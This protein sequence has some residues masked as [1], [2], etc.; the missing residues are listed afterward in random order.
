MHLLW[1]KSIIDEKGAMHQIRCKIFTFVEAKK[2]LL[3]PKL[4]SLLIHVKH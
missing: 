2:K 3:V 1:A 4:D